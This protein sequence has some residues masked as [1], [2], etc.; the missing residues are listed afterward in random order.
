META[1]RRGRARY[2]VGFFVLVV[3]TA[4]ELG[5]IRRVDVEHAA[6]VTEL[7]ELAMAKAA[8]LVWVFMDLRAQPR[9]VKALALAPLLFAPGFT[10][11]LMLDTVHRVAAR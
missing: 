1:G 11:V 3:L 7:C 2:I 8:R 4:L 5:V 9:V 10:I 6:R